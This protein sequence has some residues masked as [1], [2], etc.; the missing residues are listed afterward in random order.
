MN[1]TRQQIPAGISR[2][3]QAGQVI[4]TRTWRKGGNPVLRIIVAVIWNGFFLLMFR[5]AMN[6]VD[7]VSARIVIFAWGGVGIY[8]AYS[9]LATLLNTTVV[10]ISPDLLRVTTGPIPSH[11]EIRLAPAEI[12]NV[13]YRE[14]GGGGYSGSFYWVAAVTATGGERILLKRLAQYEDA[15]FHVREIRSV[16]GLPDAALSP[17]TPRA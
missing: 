15:I 5:P 12:R 3:V 6:D 10:E 1:T 11:G 9:C 2:E 8:L 16:L 4:I 13:I 7:W 14:T 17:E